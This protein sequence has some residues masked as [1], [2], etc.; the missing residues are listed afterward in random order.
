ML[1]GVWLGVEVGMTYVRVSVRVSVMVGVGVSVRVG[2]ITV[3]TGSV[4]LGVALNSG[5]VA[6]NVAVGADGV[7]RPR[8][9]S[10]TSRTTPPNR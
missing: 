5:A 2:K 9:P 6:A 3:G 1:V 10:F 8:I 7:T 4:G